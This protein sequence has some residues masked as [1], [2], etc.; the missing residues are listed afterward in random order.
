MET[1]SNLSLSLSTGSNP[2]ASQAVFIIN[3][4]TVMRQKLLGTQ[5]GDTVRNTSNE[6]CGCVN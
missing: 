3:L 2:L 1:A 4:M 6:R 5:S